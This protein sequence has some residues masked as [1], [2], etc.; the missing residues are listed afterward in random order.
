VNAQ[1]RGALSD[2]V[3]V[4]TGGG[5]GIG[6]AV[7]AA[8]VA[9][10]A[11]VAVLEIDPGKCGALSDFGDAVV[12]VPGDATT[13]EDNESVV[14]VAMERW[15]RIDVAVTFVGVFDLYTPL[16]E[17]PD[18]RFD[19]AFD[20]VFGLNVKSPLLTARA[21]LG[22]LR[23]ARGSIIF[24]LSS[25]S[26]YAG[27]G[28]PLYVASKFALR[29]LVVQLAHELAPDVRVNGVAPGGT[30]AT[31][32][33]GPRS[34]GLGAVRLDDRPGRAE[35]LEERTPLGVALTGADHAGAYVFLASDA[36][37]GMTGEIVRSDGGLGVR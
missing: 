19:D 14:A 6:R 18:D 32:L 15:G 28:G 7:V 37:R 30:V 9:E 31:D 1:R 3:V 8:F 35:Q 2:R 4:C 12:A 25:S 27:R 5:S 22:A 33:R 36:S 10:G 24:T 21:A 11:K 23:E 26:F 13:R 16:V 17:I 34:L 29:G 20:E